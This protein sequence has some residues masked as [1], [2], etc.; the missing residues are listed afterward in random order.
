MTKLRLLLDEDVQDDVGEEIRLWNALNVK[1]IRE[2]SLEGIKDSELL[3]YA[4]KERRIVVTFESRMNEHQ[5][6][7]CTHSGIIVVRPKNDSKKIEMFR[8]LMLSGL[9]ARCVHAVT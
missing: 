5:Y 9:R 4:T 2:L 6:R 8:S 3:A 7:I 1:S